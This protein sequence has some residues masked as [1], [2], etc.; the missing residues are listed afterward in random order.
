M[1]NET[2]FSSDTAKHSMYFNIAQRLNQEFEHHRKDYLEAMNR[3]DE[4]AAKV[5]GHTMDVVENLARH[6]AVSLGLGD[7]E[8]DKDAFLEAA[9]GRWA[10]D[11]H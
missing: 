5:P 7:P 8:L 6:I 1:M 3:G 4:S 10:H 9:L 11:R 2:K